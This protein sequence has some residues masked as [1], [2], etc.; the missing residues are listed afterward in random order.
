MNLYWIWNID[1][2]YG[3][4]NDANQKEVLAAACGGEVATMQVEGGQ[5]LVM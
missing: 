5:G 4:G 2:E 3:Y 1:M